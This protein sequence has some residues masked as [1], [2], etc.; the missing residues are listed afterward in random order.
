MFR[1]AAGDKVGSG[2]QEV[3]QRIARDFSAQL[4]TGETRESE[5]GAGR[6]ARD[7]CVIRCGGEACKL[8]GVWSLDGAGETVIVAV[9]GR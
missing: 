9:K 4:Q 5:M 2:T 8:P 3:G 7:H 1:R 6:D